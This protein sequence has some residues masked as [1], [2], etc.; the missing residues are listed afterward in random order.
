M[1]F[2]AFLTLIF[3][4]VYENHMDN[5]RVKRHN[6]IMKEYGVYNFWEMK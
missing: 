3:Q 5:V 4:G 6:Q 1:A 2:L